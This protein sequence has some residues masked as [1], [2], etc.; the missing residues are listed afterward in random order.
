MPPS[1]IENR[2]INK[3]GNASKKNIRIFR[4]SDSTTIVVLVV[5]VGPKNE[6]RRLSKK[7]ATKNKMLHNTNAL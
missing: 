4:N 5:E 2:K 7:R 6:N 3:T 1:K